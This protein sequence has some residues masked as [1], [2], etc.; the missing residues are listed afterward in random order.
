[1]KKKWLASLALV[2]TLS[3]CS[4]IGD[5]PPKPPSSFQIPQALDTTL[6]ADGCPTEEPCIG[7]EAE[8]KS[9]FDA[10]E[11]RAWAAF[12]SYNFKPVDTSEEVA[13]EFVDATDSSDTEV[14][15]PSYWRL[16]D[17]NNHD[18]VYIFHS[19]ALTTM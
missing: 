3:G 7:Y 14:L 10:L 6:G 2:S 15:P 8:E 18:V 16:P 11:A 5:E 13:Q 19:V 1:L 9:M 4:Y 17:P 12:D